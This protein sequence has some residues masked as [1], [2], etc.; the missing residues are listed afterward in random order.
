MAYG[1]TLMNLLFPEDEPRLDP[2]DEDP[3]R[4]GGGGGGPIKDFGPVLGPT[5]SLRPRDAVI[6][7]SGGSGGRRLKGRTPSGVTRHGPQ[8]VWEDSFNTFN[9]WEWLNNLAGNT[10]QMWPELEAGHQ[11]QN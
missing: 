9:L 8:E 10:G 4:F 1:P 5:R 2:F 6:D 7:T 3:I 11:W